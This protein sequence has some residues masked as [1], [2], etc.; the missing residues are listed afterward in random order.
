[1]EKCVFEH[2]DYCEALTEKL[3]DACPFR[4][5]QAEFEKGRK[6][7]LCRIYMLPAIKQ[8]KIKEKYYKGMRIF[9]GG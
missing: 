8:R 6:K 4:K 1:M 9:Y 2:G 5:T 3:C 7:A